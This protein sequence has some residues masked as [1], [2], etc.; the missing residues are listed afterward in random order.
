MST[1]AVVAVQCKTGWQ[2]TTVHYD[3]NT[4]GPLLARW[5]KDIRKAR[6]LV[7]Y[8]YI[9]FL[10]SDPSLI[11]ADPLEEPLEVLKQ[12]QIFGVRSFCSHYYFLADK[13]NTKWV[14]AKDVTDK[15]SH[16][17]KP[18]II[19][20]H[21]VWVDVRRSNGSYF[22]HVYFGEEKVMDIG[23]EK[24]AG[25]NFSQVR[26]A[27]QLGEKL[28]EFMRQVE[29]FQE[30]GRPLIKLLGDPKKIFSRMY[31]RD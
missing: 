22:I 2:Y 8:E 26:Q 16:V 13:P 21:R 10:P 24:M 20:D 17:I 28:Y 23:P 7:R 3:G 30:E 25:S 14:Y 6:Q 27:Q 12:E 4:I 29:Y 19:P 1:N 5:Y 9:K 18:G 15:G 31:E 11:N